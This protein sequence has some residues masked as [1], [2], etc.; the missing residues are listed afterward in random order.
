M[1]RRHGLRKDDLVKVQLDAR[2][3]RDDDPT[4]IEAT[5]IFA[6]PEILTADGE[7]STSPEKLLLRSY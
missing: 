7:H 3:L 1:E 5:I 6:P 2:A 4:W